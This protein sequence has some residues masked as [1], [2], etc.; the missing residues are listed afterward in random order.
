MKRYLLSSA[1]ILTATLSASSF[2]ETINYTCSPASSIRLGPPM[3][4]PIYDPN[5]GRMVLTY[6]WSMTGY[7][8]TEKENHV[9]DT[10]TPIYSF[11]ETKSASDRPIANIKPGPL[12]LSNP[13]TAYL[14]PW[15]DG[16]TAIRCKYQ[17]LP[18]DS[19]FNVMDPGT[20]WGRFDASSC[21]QLNQTTI[22]CNTSPDP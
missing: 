2:A 1:F 17:Y 14:S 9:I 21:T 8:I 15:G 10:P 11:I 3:A 5:E 18:P 19:V 13:V 6:V 22:Q 16:T 20:V 7:L 4:S 12:R